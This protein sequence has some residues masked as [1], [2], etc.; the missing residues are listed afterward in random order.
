MKLVVIES[1]YAGNVAVN[2]EYARS[3]MRDCLSRGESPYASHLLYTQPGVLDDTVPEERTLGIAAGF[4]WAAQAD[5][6][7]V[8]VDLGMS[9]GMGQG[10][11]RALKSGQPVE[12]RTLCGAE[13][14]CNTWRRLVKWAKWD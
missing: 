1:P 10:V 12:F 7:A 8:Y 14:V 3:A 6:I 2:E 9:R 5:L 4:A 13:E 11:A